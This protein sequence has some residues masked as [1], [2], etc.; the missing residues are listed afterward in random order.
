MPKHRLIFDALHEQI[1]AGKFTDGRRLPSEMELAQRYK[2]SRPTAARALRDL[3]Q[4][5]LLERRAGSGTYLRSQ[6]TVAARGESM[7]LGLLV[8]GLG[9]TEILDPICNE[10]TRAAQAKHYS[11]LW[12]D[13]ASTG[14]SAEQA[15]A[16]CQQCIDRQVNGVFFAPLETIPDREKVNRQIVQ[17]LADAGIAVVLLDRDVL[18]FPR[19]STFDLVGIDNFQ[20]AYTLADY[21]A[22]A[23]RK[24]FRFVAKQGYPSTTDLRMAGCREAVFRRGLKVDADWAQFGDPSDATFVRG[25]LDPMPDV[26]VCANDLTA[27]L[28]IQ[29]LTNLGVR[30]PQDISVVGFDDVRYAT[31]LSVPLTTIR[32]PCVRIGQA[33]VQAMHERIQTPSLPARQILLTGKLIIRRSCGTT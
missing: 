24:N 32:Q 14:P 26:I 11:V 33:A 15:M 21:L 3:T 6:P 7:S 27:A 10:I 25:L 31:L 23:G 4:M 20:A 29:T 12:G 2:V 5:G 17:K 28:L 16:V 22:A 19:R 1:T 30:I 18:D 8:P 9:N 13:A